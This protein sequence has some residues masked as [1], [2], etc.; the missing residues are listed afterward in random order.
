MTA[1]KHLA[2]VPIARQSIVDAD[3]LVGLVQVATS[4]S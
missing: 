2:G 1:L 3:G 4:T